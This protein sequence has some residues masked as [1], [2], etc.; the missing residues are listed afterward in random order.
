M[1]PEAVPGLGAR[2]H[3]QAYRA[4]REYRQRYPGKAVIY[5]ADPIGDL[6]WAVFMA[7]G[8]LA[9]IPRISQAGLLARRARA[10]RMVLFH[11]SPKYQGCG[12]LFEE[13]AWRAFEG[14]E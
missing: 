6:A 11:F 8:S 3:A 14:R 13:E 4:V 2:R 1:E 10:K 9:G 5:S 7:G 12:N